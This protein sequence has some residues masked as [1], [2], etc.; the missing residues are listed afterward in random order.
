MIINFSNTYC[1]GFGYVVGRICDAGSTGRPQPVMRR[2]VCDVHSAAIGPAMEP[3]N[4]GVGR[5]GEH[6]IEERTMKRF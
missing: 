4:S 6:V 3:G 2:P 5:D 1:A